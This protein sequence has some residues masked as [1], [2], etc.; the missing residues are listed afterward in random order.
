MESSQDFQALRDAVQPALVTVT[1]SANSIANEDLAFQRTVHSSVD[2]ELDETTSRMLKITT[3]LLKSAGKV[4]GQKTYVLEDTDDIDIRWKGIVDV[5]D[6]LL[7][8]AD[9]CLDEYTGLIKR[10]NGPVAEARSSI[11]NAAKP[12]SMYT[13]LDYSLKRANILKPQNAFERPVNNFEPGPWKPLLTT[14]PHAQVPLEQLSTFANEEEET[15]YQHPYLHEIT[16]LQY[17]S[18]VYE[19][20][21]PIKYTPM[22]PAKPKDGCIW[23]DTFEGVLEMLEELKKA[24]EIAIDLEHHDFRT[25]TGLLSL[26]QVSTRDKDWIVD[27]LVPWRHKLEVLNEVFADPKILKV[28]HG[29]YMDIIWLQRDL[30][31][32]VVGLFDTHHASDVLLYS[33]RSLAFLLKKFV[34]FDADK[35]YQLA[36]WR[37]RPLP[38]EMFYYARSDTHFLLYIF[39]MLRNELIEAANKQEYQHPDGGAPLE[40]VLQKSKEVSLQRYEHPTLD[41]ETGFGSRGWYN[42][43][44]K[45]SALLNGEQFAVYKAVFAWRDKIARQED[46]SPPFIMT[47]QMILDIARIIPIDKKALWSLLDTNAR[48]L[49]VHLDDLFETIQAAKEKG[50]NG[51]TLMQFLREGSSTAIEKAQPTVKSTDTRSIEELKSTFSQLWGNVP[52]SS[53]WEQKSNVAATEGTITIPLFSQFHVVDDEPA[54]ETVKAEKPALKSEPAE[55][56]DGGF[57]L[58]AGS[59]KRKAS[60]VEEEEVAAGSDVEMGEA[61]EP[62]STTSEG[63]S[64]AEERTEED[65]HKEAREAKKAR[66][67]AKKAAKLAKKQE[68]QEEEEEEEVFDYSK[69]ETVLKTSGGNEDDKKG[70]KKGKKGKKAFDPYAFKSGNAPAGARQMNF[71]RAGRSATFK[72]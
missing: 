30:S 19:T 32:Y 28:F 33:G 44:I 54:Q 39:D 71:E 6:T 40:R 7:E 10:N 42:I 24:T 29:A 64:K 58:K 51:S 63:D 17:P 36:D 65:A 22:D 57:T 52:L 50:A 59:R 9:T 26:M 53:A 37:I 3:D 25:Y 2:R 72:K 20:K 31:L 70:G 4:T 55:E 38:D 16:N 45:S 43:L 56:D 68:E 62:E 47:Q 21:E 12:K 67:A 27:T 60:D 41:P 66:K 34:D 18:H 13:K 14:K 1:R 49:K 69:A 48:Q 23:V 8:K 35:K 61:G 15:Q 46:E 11:N 5:I